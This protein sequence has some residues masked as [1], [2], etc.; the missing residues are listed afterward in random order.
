MGAGSGGADSE[1]WLPTLL[2]VEQLPESRSSTAAVAQTHAL[3][4][5]DLKEERKPHYAT[6]RDC[7][8]CVW[9]RA[10]VG[11]RVS[12]ATV[13]F[14]TRKSRRWSLLWARAALGAR[15]DKRVSRALLPSAS[16]AD[17][18]ISFM[19]QRRTLPKCNTF[20]WTVGTSRTVAT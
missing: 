10:R 13:S 20:R 1:G 18:Y 19:A 14:L 15:G 3:I 17:I 9:V 5:A 7:P 8:S 2:P 11:M 6:A 4:R 12:P 16:N